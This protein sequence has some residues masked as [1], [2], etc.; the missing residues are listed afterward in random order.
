MVTLR[1]KK[2]ENSSIYVNDAFCA[3]HFMRVLIRTV[4][5]NLMCVHT[6]P[7]K[8]LIIS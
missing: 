2:D 6:W 3:C 8:W 7:Y 1:T 4:L 5:V